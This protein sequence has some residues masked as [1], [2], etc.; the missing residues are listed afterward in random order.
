MRTLRNTFYSSQVE[1]DLGAG[2]GG[3]YGLSYAVE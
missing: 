1:E 3:H 2:R